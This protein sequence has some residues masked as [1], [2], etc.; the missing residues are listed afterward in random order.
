VDDRTGDCPGDAGDALDLGN[1]QLAKFI[2]TRRLSANDDVVRTRDIFGQCDALNSAALPTLVWTKMYACT[3]IGTPS[4]PSPRRSAFVSR[5][6]RTLAD[7][8]T[9][10][11]PLL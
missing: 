10:H 3:T 1:H 6:P 2:H 5:W 7:V 4:L 9:L 8:V 11:C